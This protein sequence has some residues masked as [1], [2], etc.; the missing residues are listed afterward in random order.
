MLVGYESRKVL[1]ILDCVIQNLQVSIIDTNA[2]AFEA[3]KSK[4]IHFQSLRFRF[5]FRMK[6]EI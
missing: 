4:T 6:V 2:H 3:N 1:L 5:T